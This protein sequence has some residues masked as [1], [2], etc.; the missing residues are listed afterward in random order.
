MKQKIALVTGSNK[1][2]G[3]AIVKE[4]AQAGYEVWLAARNADLGKKAAA[5]A[6][7]NVHFLPLDVTDDASV[8]AAAKLFSSQR[9]HLDLLVNN[10]G[11]FLSDGDGPPSAVSIKTINKVFDV[12]FLGPIRVSQAFLPLIKKSQQ[13]KVLNVSSG[14]GSH[15]LDLDDSPQGLAGVNVLAYNSSK[16]ALNMFSVL[17]SNELKA[18]K[19]AVNSICPGHVATDLNGHSGNLTTQESAKGIMEFINKDG[20][21]TGHFIKKGGEH[22][23]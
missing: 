22:P 5:E 15:T 10:A 12:N 2:I 6:G 19:I 9:D 8:A 14:L 3:F 1:G 16:S 13:G 17:L 23:W 18:A 11:I 20:F 4:L 7:G 21:T